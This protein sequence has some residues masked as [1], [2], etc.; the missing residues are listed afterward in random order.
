MVNAGPDRGIALPQNTVALDGTVSDDGL[1]TG[2]VTTTWS[3]VAGGTGAGTVS[4]GDPNAVDTTAT[5]TSDPGTYVLRLEANDGLLSAFDEMTVT[6]WPSPVSLD[7]QVNAESDDAEHRLTADPPF[8]SLTSSD[9]ELVVDGV[10]QQVVGIRFNGINVP[11]GAPITA[12]YLQFTTDDND[13]DSEATDLTIKGEATDNAVTFTSSA[14]NMSSRPRTVASVAWAPPPWLTTGVAGPDQR[15]PDLSAIIQE[16]V[17][18]PGW[19]STNSLALIISGSGARTAEAFDIPAAAP[20][21]H[22]EYAGVQINIAPVI[23]AGLDQ[24]L[25]LPENTAVLDATVSDD[26]LPGGP[27]TTTWSRAGGSG[28]G[29]VTFADPA[30]V[31]TTATISPP[32]AGTYVLRLTADDGELSD[33]DEVLIVLSDGGDVDSITQVNYYDT[34]FDT[35]GGLPGTQLTIPSIDPA[36]LTYHPPS[37]RLFIADSEINETPAFNIVQASL[38]QADT[39]GSALIDQWDLTQPPIGNSEPTG[40]AFC[41]SDGHFYVTNDDA[42]LIYRYAYDGT[43]FTAVDA[44]STSA[45]SNDPEGITCD[46]VSGRIYA[47]GG[48]GQ[49][50]LVYEYNS[51]FVFLD[52]LDLPTTAGTPSGVP[53]DPEGIAFD[54]VSGHLFVVSDPDKAIFEY[55]QSGLFIK[56]FDID[57]LTPAHKAPQGLSIGTSSANPQEMSFYIAD[58][59]IDN[60]SDPDERDGRIYEMEIQRFQ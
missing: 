12:A 7:F 43:S 22:I 3:H 10:V 48:Q 37:G 42:K 30:A 46:P 34:G 25:I 39:S 52:E 32:D 29:T 50:I 15:S 41:T 2:N 24:T 5:F 49:K 17:D 51:G 1:P 26:G 45:Y 4:F 36:G 18:R 9:L 33:F 44:V 54:P 56:K 35:S 28:T 47:I 19:T 57:V 60:D 53:S 58:G 55:T 21:L 6:V 20:R 14:T 31:D 27:I 59:I 40:I 13:T 23:D 16:I 38:F 11:Q 8:V